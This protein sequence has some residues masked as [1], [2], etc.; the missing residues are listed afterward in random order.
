MNYKEQITTIATTHTHSYKYISNQDVKLES[1]AWTSS[2]TSSMSCVLALDS[3][4]SCSLQLHHDNTDTGTHQHF[5]TCPHHR[6]PHS[7][8]HRLDVLYYGTPI[9]AHTASRLSPWASTGMRAVWACAYATVKYDGGHINNPDLIP[10]AYTP[11][12]TK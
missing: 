1:Q 8:T 9:P 5:A 4:H 10:W 6:P 11:P 12:R 3:L 7:P 2:R